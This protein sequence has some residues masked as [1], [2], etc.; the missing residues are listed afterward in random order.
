MFSRYVLWSVIKFEIHPL[1]IEGR[2]LWITST[3]ERAGGYLCRVT[4]WNDLYL[5][6]L[7]RTICS[8]ISSFSR[9]AIDS[10]IHTATELG[11][12]VELF[13]SCLSILFSEFSENKVSTYRTVMYTELSLQRTFEKPQGNCS[14]LLLLHLRDLEMS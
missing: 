9:L 5:L 12:P 4:A 13:S 1:T 7:F 3:I 11:L 6:L 2:G 8:K 10:D 14:L